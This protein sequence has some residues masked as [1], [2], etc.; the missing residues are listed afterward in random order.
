MSDNEL[1]NYDLDKLYSMSNISGDFLP[2]KCN[3][4]TTFAN[5]KYDEQTS[6]EDRDCNIF[7]GYGHAV[8]FHRW[9][10]GNSAHWIPLI[11]NKN[12]EVIV[13][14]SL[15]KNGLLKEK[16]VINRLLD[17]LMNN[18]IQKV[19]FNNKPFQG[20]ETNTCGKWSIFVI[21]MNKMI[22]GCGIDDIISH[23]EK[24]KKQFGSYDNYMLNLFSNEDI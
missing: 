9:S 15:G 8:L 13:F 7:N 22:P 18:G 24:M 20:N 19:T 1:S 10:D 12:N 3:I 5:D 16:E 2:Q 6:L 4:I 21:S 17:C 11:R 23:L 14:D